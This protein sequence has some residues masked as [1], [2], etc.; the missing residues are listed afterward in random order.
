[1]SAF[2]EIKR[3]FI[4]DLAKSSMNDWK[5]SGKYLGL[6]E[7]VVPGRLFDRWNKKFYAQTEVKL[8]DQPRLVNHFKLGADPEFVFVV[9]GKVIHASGLGLKA[10][11]AFGAD[12]NGR[13]AELR[14]KPSRSALR[15]VASLYAELCFLAQWNP[16]LTQYAWVASPFAE[17]DGLG[18]HVHFGRW[19]KL[20]E[21]EVNALD[22]VMK[23]LT[24]A[25]VIN[26]AAQRNRLATN[27]YGKFGDIRVQSHGYEYRTFPTWLGS[28]KHAHLFLTLAKLAVHAPSMFDGVHSP[29]GTLVAQRHI[30]NILAYYQDLDDDAKIARCYFKGCCVPNDGNIQKNWNIVP[31]FGAEGRAETDIVPQIVAP[32][33]QHIK[34]MFSLLTTG[35]MVFETK[36]PFE[37]L[38]FPKGYTPFQH[39][40]ATDRRPDLGEL[41]WD[42]A[43]VPM[44]I[45]LGM[46]GSHIAPDMSLHVTR[47]LFDL[48]QGS[49]KDRVFKTPDGTV[50]TLY[51]V[52]SEHIGISLPAWLLGHEYKSW[53]K[54]FLTESGI[55]PFVRFGQEHVQKEWKMRSNERLLLRA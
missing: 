43:M 24:A 41:V 30:E 46:V 15:V 16:G 13:L 9:D 49:F 48:I 19:K 37:I 45:P 34:E 50:A 25:G 5:A 26:L 23:L 29:I 4:L 32:S 18:G 40:M 1:M 55:F 8:T 27:L 54:S 53:T 11:L 12:N 14:P 38:R 44:K 17:R 51:L 47:P 39:F 42:M 35:K 52:N 20:R 31:V 33:E 10:G 21:A 28:P 2:K 7:A 36:Q 6:A 3:D 22:W